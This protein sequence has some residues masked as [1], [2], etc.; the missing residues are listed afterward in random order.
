MMAKPEW[1]DAPEWANY[2]AQD[3]CGIWFWFELEPFADGDWVEGSSHGKIEVA[4][5]RSIEWYATLEP[6]P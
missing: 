1:K 5:P 6:R 3:P 2:F 4:Q